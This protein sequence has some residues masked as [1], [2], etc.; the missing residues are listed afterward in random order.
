MRIRH[1]S[2]GTAKDVKRTVGY[3]DSMIVEI[4]RVTIDHKI[5]TAIPMRAQF[6]PCIAVGIKMSHRMIAI[7]VSQAVGLA[8]M[9]VTPTIVQLIRIVTSPTTNAT[10]RSVIANVTFGGRAAV[11]I[12]PGADVDRPNDGAGRPHFEQNVRPGSSGFP[13]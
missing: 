11:A 8:K 4:P 7:G 12:V 10:M 6:I 13:Q 5:S 1:V 9:R 2:Q 3:L